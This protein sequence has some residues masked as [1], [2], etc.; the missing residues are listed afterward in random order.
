MN[1]NERKATIW[2]VNWFNLGDDAEICVFTDEEKAK[3]LYDAKI[4]H[5]D[6]VNMTEHTIYV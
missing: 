6:R 1:Y 3:E 2:V 4:G 5:Y